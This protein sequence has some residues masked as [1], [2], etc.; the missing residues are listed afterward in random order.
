MNHSS[1]RIKGSCEDENPLIKRK[2]SIELMM[3]FVE[4]D[5]LPSWLETQG[6]DRN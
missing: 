3:V 6:W 1:N 2:T 5:F 4:K